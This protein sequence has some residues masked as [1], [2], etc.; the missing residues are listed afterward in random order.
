MIE[1]RQDQIGLKVGQPHV[2]RRPTQFAA[3]EVQEQH[4]RIAVAGNRAGAER[5]LRDQVLGEELLDQ[6]G[7]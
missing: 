2:R 6:R 4:Q 3:C 1:E 5:A 7:E